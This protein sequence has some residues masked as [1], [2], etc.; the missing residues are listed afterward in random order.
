MR[1]LIFALCFLLSNITANVAASIDCS[2]LTDATM[3]AKCIVSD[4][5]DTTPP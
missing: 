1:Y 3:R 5:V 4:R 2:K